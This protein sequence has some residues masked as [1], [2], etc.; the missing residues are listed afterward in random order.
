[1]LTLC[2]DTSFGI[3]S[4]SLLSSK[5]C[6]PRLVCLFSNLI[7]YI[8]CSAVIEKGRKEQH[9]LICSQ[10]ICDVPVLVLN[11]LFELKIMGT[12]FLCIC[13]WVLDSL[14]SN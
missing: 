11:I 4:P 9:F 14:V 5:K 3:N 8:C 2:P 1:M 7:L 12:V 6:Y 13:A 10:L